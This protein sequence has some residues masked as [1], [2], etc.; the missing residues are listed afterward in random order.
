MYL[1][2]KELK[3]LFIIDLDAM[4]YQKFST[5]TSLFD[6]TPDQVKRI[7]VDGERD[8]I[9]YFTEENGKYPGVHGRDSRGQ[10]YTILEGQDYH[11]DETTG[12]AF[13]PDGRHLYIAFQK[14]GVL[15]D[16]TRDDG[17]PFNGKTLNVKYHNVAAV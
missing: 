5:V 14:V 16:V 9:L 8:S 13:S 2:S 6:G 4:T 1:V 3:A 11:G 7:L 12:L 17:Y 15:F 10:F